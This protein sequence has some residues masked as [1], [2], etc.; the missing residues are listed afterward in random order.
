ML[1][2]AIC[3][4]S[5][6]DRDKIREYL[7][8]L[9]AE[10]FSFSCQSFKDGFTL[11]KA[12]QQGKRFDLIILAM[13]MRGRDGIATAHFIRHYDNKVPFLAVSYSA[14]PAIECFEL[15][16]RSYLLKPLEK[17]KFL[18]TVR[19]LLRNITARESGYYGFHNE[20]GWHKI[21]LSDILYF[22]SHLRKIK[23]RTW[24]AEYRFTASIK[25]IEEQLSG[26]HFI[27]VHKS[28]I[29]NLTHLLKFAGDSLLLLNKETIPVSKHR[30]KN[31]K[32]KFLMFLAGHTSS[33]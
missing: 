28:F 20:Q 14:A 2:I 9:K 21:K 13:L 1:A 8:V 12:Y 16:V 15:G 17:Q 24:A 25:A 6:E 31:L 10:K 22:E 4:N 33:Y 5:Q 11:G 26:Q 27:R 32:T 18:T 29:I 7:Q 30:K 23:L 3:D 19:K